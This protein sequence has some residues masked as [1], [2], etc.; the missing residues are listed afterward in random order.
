MTQMIKNSL[1]QVRWNRNIS[2]PAIPDSGTEV[3]SY[4]HCMR[5]GV[6][7]YRWIW[8]TLP[9]IHYNDVIMSAMAS[10]ITSL[11]IVYSIFYSG[12]DQRKH[13]GSASLAFVR[14][15]NRWPVNSPHKGPVTRKMFLC[16]DVIMTSMVLWQ[17][18]NSEEFESNYWFKFGRG[19]LTTRHGV[20]NQG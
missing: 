2:L 15:I 12:A 19:Q 17:W 14:G 7:R 13:Q 18:S 8:F 11:T 4:A 9:R 1:Y 3:L 10:Q 5:F 16:D 6:V 20:S